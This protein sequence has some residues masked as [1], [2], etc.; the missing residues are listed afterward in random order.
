MG[1]EELEEIRNKYQPSELKEFAKRAAQEAKAAK[2]RYEK[3]KEAR[4]NAELEQLHREEVI[5]SAATAEEKIV[6]E[7]VEKEKKELKKLVTKE[8]N[9]GK[10]VIEKK[11]LDF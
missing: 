6:L 2:E 1:H 9:K 4:I 8:N 5:K 3:E 11:W 7:K 10:N